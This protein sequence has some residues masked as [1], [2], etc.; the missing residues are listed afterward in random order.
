MKNICNA[1][2]LQIAGSIELLAKIWPAYCSTLE[3]NTIRPKPAA[4]DWIMNHLPKKYQ[5]VMKRA[6]SIC[7]GVEKE[8][9][10]DLKEIIKPCADFMV[11]KI[12]AQI[13][14]INFDVPNELIKLAEE[15]FVG[16]H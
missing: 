9:W 16:D 2:A 8:Y 11:D 12:N 3:T 5:P 6:K 13:L 14:L 4:V 7:I 1:K 15:P 10:D